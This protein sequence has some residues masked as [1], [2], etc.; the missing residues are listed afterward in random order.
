MSLWLTTTR[1]YGTELPKSALNT[2]G[3]WSN[4]HCRT[5][6]FGYLGARCQCYSLLWLLVGFHR[7]PV[8]G[9]CRKVSCESQNDPKVL[10]PSRYGM[11]WALWLRSVGAIFQT[12]TV[13]PCPTCILFDAFF[14]A[15]LIECVFT[16]R[17]YE[18]VPCSLLGEAA[19]LFSQWLQLEF[20]KE[21]NSNRGSRSET[22]QE[23]QFYPILIY[24]IP[25]YCKCIVAPAIQAP[26]QVGSK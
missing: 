16:F 1:N 3:C 20:S 24:A 4:E 19:L 21:F 11:L 17:S 26:G 8:A 2:K 10:I 9:L 13:C 12:P 23:F 7:D 15:M 14:F 25:I 22:R 6:I 18:P 5:A